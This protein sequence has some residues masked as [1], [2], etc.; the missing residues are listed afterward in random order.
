[1][2]APVDDKDTEWTSGD[3][4]APGQFRGRYEELQSYCA[5]RYSNY[6]IHRGYFEQSIDDSFLASMD[7]RPPALI[8]ID[9]DYNSS[10]KVIFDRLKDRIPNGCV[11]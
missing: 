1:M 9:C 8:W 10:A 11:I 2:P 6:E 4:W 3:N 7:R 5:A